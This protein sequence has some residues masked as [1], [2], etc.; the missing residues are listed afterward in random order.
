MHLGWFERPKSPSDFKQELHVQVIPQE[1]TSTLSL[2]LDTKS[3]NVNH[4]AVWLDLLE[5]V[6][7]FLFFV[8]L[9]YLLFLCFMIKKDIQASWSDRIGTDMFSHDGGHIFYITI[10]WIFKVQITE[11]KTVHNKQEVMNILFFKQ[12]LITDS[13]HE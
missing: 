2:C 3:L 1:F 10:K 13:F 4:V 5:L 6:W 8:L 11:A 7:I 12:K 9:P